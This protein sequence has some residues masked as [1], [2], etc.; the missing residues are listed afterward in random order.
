MASELIALSRDS[1]SHSAFEFAKLNRPKPS[2]KENS[3]KSPEIDDQVKREVSADK[4]L[5]DYINFLATLRTRGESPVIPSAVAAD[6]AND[7][8]ELVAFSA[9][10]SSSID[11]V[12]AAYSSDAGSAVLAAAH[13]ELHA[14]MSAEIVAPD[15]SHFTIEATVDVSVDIAVAG[16]AVPT[17]SDPLAL[18]LNG[19]GEIS[20]TDLTSG[21]D[22]D[23]N[24]DGVLDRSAFIGGGDGFLALDRNEN[25]AIDDGSELFGDQNGA[26][27]GFLELARF[28][29]DASG[30]IDSRDS[31]FSKLL[32]ASI[33][34]G[35]ALQARSLA[36]AGVKSL[37]LAYRDVNEQGAYGNKIAQRGSFETANGEHRSA[38][39]A[40]LNFARI[41]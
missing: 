27:N 1:K 15:G 34:D 23:L 8:G 4:Q 29:D 36:S 39:D 13:G 19:D 16:S 17:Q 10:I 5:N 33:G 18:D 38:V 24:A 21:I 2:A 12:A 31:L 41:G 14:E 26:A 40:L 22:F 35:G 30:T 37:S 3:P 7:G 6:E 9:E 25:G 20:L 11:T 28:D 32:I